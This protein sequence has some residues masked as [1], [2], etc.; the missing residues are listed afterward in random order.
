M[1]IDNDYAEAYGEA[2]AEDYLSQPLTTRNT[3]RS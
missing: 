3:Y 2:G 1:K